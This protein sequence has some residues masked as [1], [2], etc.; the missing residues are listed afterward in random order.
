MVN[1]RL[2]VALLW[3]REKEVLQESQDKKG[4][5]ALWAARDPEG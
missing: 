4:V 2:H 1:Q 3:L 5:L